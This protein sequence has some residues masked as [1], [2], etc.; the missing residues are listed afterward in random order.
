[1][2][3]SCGLR[4]MKT[5]IKERK[6]E[7]KHKILIKGKWVRTKK[8]TDERYYERIRTCMM[9]HTSLMVI[10][11]VLMQ[12]SSISDFLKPQYISFLQSSGVLAKTSSKDHLG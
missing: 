4:E 9:L 11:W 1:M 10:S 6:K 2:D 7:K 8:R 3:S 5:E 12:R